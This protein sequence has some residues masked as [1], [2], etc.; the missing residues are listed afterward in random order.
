MEQTHTQPVQVIP[1]T[2]CADEYMV[3]YGAQHFVWV[4]GQLIPVS[5]V[6]ATH[7]G[8]TG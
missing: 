2:V 3:I 8:M 5:P 6:S 1:Q 4:K 7:D